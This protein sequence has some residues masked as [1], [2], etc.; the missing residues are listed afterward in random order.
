MVVVML[1]LLISIIG[2]TFGAVSEVNDLIYEKNRLMLVTEFVKF[3]YQNPNNRIEPIKNHYLITLFKQ[4]PE[5]SNKSE[6][7]L[8]LQIIQKTNENVKNF[9][10]STS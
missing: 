5:F 10:F 9:F 4:N 7:E 8:S 6:I 1:N 3:E 2:S